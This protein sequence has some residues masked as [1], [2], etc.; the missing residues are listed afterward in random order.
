MTGIL[1]AGGDA[2]LLPKM[3]DGVKWLRLNRLSA[4]NA[5]NEPFQRALSRALQEASDD[6]GVTAVVLASMSE[7]IF[8]AGADLKEYAGLAAD[9]ARRR[10]RELLG[11]TLLQF[12]CFPKPI[13][14]CVTGQAIGA[15]CMLAFLCDEIVANDEAT[16]SLPEIRL[17]M[18][19]P[20]AA[21]I[22][23]HRGGRAAL[24]AMVLRGDVMDGVR[25][26][27][28]ALIEILSTGDFLADA[29]A[30]AMALGALD[31]NAFGRTKVWAYAAVRDEIRLALSE[32][33]RLDD[34]GLL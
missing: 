28:N 13:V 6:P 3:Q 15:G 22:A 1:P 18:V 25:A 27:S 26:K 23:R 4:A 5:I 32:S 9:V 34:L 11:E 24:Q 20:I 14:A 29:Q 17:G 33:R 8:S 21:A 19:S 10:R 2:M 31:A 12:T 16:F 7:R 30:R